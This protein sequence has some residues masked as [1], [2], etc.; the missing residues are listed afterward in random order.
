M[1]FNINVKYSSTGIEFDETKLYPVS[2]ESV[3]AVKT[4]CEFEQTVSFLKLCIAV[5]VIDCF[6][7]HIES[8]MIILR[9]ILTTVLSCGV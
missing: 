4:S 7:S 1:H 5:M 9:L 8:L 6:Y 3:Q 2:F